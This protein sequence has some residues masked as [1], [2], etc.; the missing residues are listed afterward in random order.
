MT[1]IRYPCF[2]RGR[3]LKLDMLENLRDFPREALACFCEDFSDGIV[4][5]LTPIVEKDT[6]TFSNGILKYQGNVYLVSGLAAIPY[7]ETD[8]EVA[9]KIV[10]RQKEEKPDYK[11]QHFDFFIDKNVLVAE[12]EIELFRFKLKK[13]AYLR[14]DYQDLNDFI[15]EYNTINIVHVLYA[16]YGKPTL[17]H[18]VLKYFAQ[19]ALG[20]NPQNTWDVSFAM[21]CLNSTRVERDVILNYLEQRLNSGQSLKK[22]VDL[23]NQEIHA[24]LVK[25]LVLIK[26][27]ESPRKRTLSQR[28]TITLD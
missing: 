7:E 11:A 25:V 12:N 18:L 19:V 16:G 9:V 28:A 8:T 14:S 27:E 21:L 20:Y 4:C 10:F 15:T 22:S 26:K 13:G 6:I 17:S 1:D 5:G 23:S 24:Q 2:V 3:I